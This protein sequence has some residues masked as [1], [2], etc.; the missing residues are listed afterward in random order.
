MKLVLTTLNAKYTHS[1]LALRY[2]R[3]Y[4]KPLVCEIV[5]KEFSI[6]QHSLD[7]LG[8]IY[9]E[10][11]DIVGF[12]CYIWNIE[13]TLE[14]ISLIKKVLPKV[15]IICG[16]P[17]V[18]Y[19][20]QEF[21][22]NYPQIDYLVQGEGE[23]TLYHLLNNIINEKDLSDIKAISYRDNKGNIIVGQAM[24]VQNLNTIPFAYHDQDIKELGEKI[25]YYESSR[26]CPFSC[27]YCLS[28]ATKGVR[29]FSIERVLTELKFF[30]HHHVRQVKFVDR[31]FNAKKEHYLTIWRFLAKQDC[32]TN[33]HFEIAADL[34]DEEVLAILAQ[35]PPGR[36]QLE[37]G[38]QSTNE[39]TLEKINRK[40]HWDK[41]VYNVK[42]L[43]SYNNM[44]LH[45]D[46]I[47]GLPEEN[48]DS[49]KN[50]FND[51]Y[52][53]KPNMLQIGFLKLLKGSGIARNAKAYDYVFMDTA[54]YQVLANK[55]IS[56]EEIR[57][58]QI[59]E[60]VFEQYY[61]SG[62]FKNTI[63]FLI[64]RTDE[65]AFLFYEELTNY[66][67]QN[68]FHIIAHST[69]SLYLHLFNF[70]KEKF[71]QELEMIKQFLKLDALISDKASILPDFL[72]WSENDYYEE[73]SDFW[74]GN[75]VKKY[76]PNFKFT[77]WRE[78]K[79]KHKVEIFCISI[80][81]W[82]EKKEIHKQKEAMLFSYENNSVKM[83]K[84]ADDDFGSC[85]EIM[86]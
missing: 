60:E 8:Q 67:Q 69:K 59:F 30:I 51:V 84:I 64:S 57:R 26:G 21:L 55:F 33:F 56:Y 31:T 13:M 20:P 50:S 49:F 9:E 15:K 14:L 2:L 79:K 36:I 32:R 29:Y 82:N 35:M 83:V 4:C 18:S 16:G 37:I 25:I 53:L 78:I 65:N 12:A 43:L 39:L 52:A 5:V 54:P 28:S 77:N 7:I 46:L 23:E 34:I 6:N 41:I 45:L 71:R 19:Q 61:N 66:W 44:H 68:N 27:Q 72:P 40:N 22:L 47:I 86:Q 42:K 74:R 81:R 85:K 48:Y 73:I 76:L 75:H 38:V 10:K 62:R 80:E 3:E 1:S 17:E 70:C 63:D 11:P 24:V 58:L